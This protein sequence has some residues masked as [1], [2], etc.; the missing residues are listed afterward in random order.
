[1][2]REKSGGKEIRGK[3][4]L[5]VKLDKEKLKVVCAFFEFCW[6]HWLIFEMNAPKTNK[7]PPSLFSLTLHPAPHA[8]PS[9]HMHARGHGNGQGSNTLGYKLG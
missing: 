2:Q 8:P 9:K 1:M 5:W 6:E 3:M 4:F 7:P